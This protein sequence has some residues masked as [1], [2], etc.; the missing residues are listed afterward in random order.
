[1]ICFSPFAIDFFDITISHFKRDE[2]KDTV[3]HRKVPSKYYAI[4]KFHQNVMSTCA[5]KSF[6]L[7]VSTTIKCVQACLYKQ[8][9]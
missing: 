1:M 8:L 9:V 7:H 5:D 3:D 2:I 6:C 4:E